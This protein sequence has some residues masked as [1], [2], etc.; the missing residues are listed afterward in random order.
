MGRLKLGRWWPE[1]RVNSN[2]RQCLR[3]N[4]TRCWIHQVYLS[5]PGSLKWLQVT[6][7]YPRPGSW[8][9][10]PTQ[11]VEIGWGQCVEET[12]H[13]TKIRAKTIITKK[14]VISGLFPILNSLFSLWMPASISSW[15]YPGPL[16]QGWM[17]LGVRCLGAPMTWPTSP[18]LIH[19]FIF[20]CHLLSLP[21]LS[22]QLS[23]PLANL[24]NIYS[25]F[26]LMF[27]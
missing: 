4:S 12:H 11:V 5:C 21:R 19:Q 13:L 17:L 26:L 1:N 15:S 7:A 24:L 9:S 16:L 25:G 3:E 23:G 22:F 20:P 14:Q 27:I 10:A 6:N 2:N 18:A 8:H